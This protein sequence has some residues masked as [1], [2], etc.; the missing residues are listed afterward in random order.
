MPVEESFRR[1][2]RRGQRVVVIGFFLSAAAVAAALGTVSRPPAKAWVYAKRIREG[3]NPQGNLDEI[4]RLPSPASVP[5]LES[6]VRNPHPELR[7]NQALRLIRCNMTK[8]VAEHPDGDVLAAYATENAFLEVAIV[9]RKFADF[10]L[11][12]ER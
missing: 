2:A 5:M 8:I 3:R 7:A 10:R 4:A 9:E 1:G 11:G 6:F 12:A